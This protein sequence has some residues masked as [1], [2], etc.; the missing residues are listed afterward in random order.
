MI[1]SDLAAL[2]EVETTRLKETVRRHPNK[3]PKNFMF[4]RV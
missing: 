1:D 2:C 3:F 4:E